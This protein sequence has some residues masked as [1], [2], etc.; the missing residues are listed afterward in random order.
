[1]L[2]IYHTLILDLYGRKHHEYSY[3][4]Q[5]W[6][7]CSWQQIEK[8]NYMNSW[9][10]LMTTSTSLIKSSIYKDKTSSILST[11]KTSWH[12]AIDKKRV[13]W[14]KICWPDWTDTRLNTRY[15]HSSQPTSE[16]TTRSIIAQNSNITV[17]HVNISGENNLKESKIMT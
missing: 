14:L 6:L 12:F 1:L 2:K 4:N 7:N 13:K 8:A 5:Q 11:L 16:L 17:V 15:F 3:L 10:M 9:I